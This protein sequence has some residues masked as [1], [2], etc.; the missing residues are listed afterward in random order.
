MSRAAVL[1][2]VLAATGCAWFG[3]GDPLGRRGPDVADLVRDLPD[4]A[5]PPARTD[6]PTRAEVMAAYERIYGRIPDP[7]EDHAVGRRL[8]DL[9]MSVGED[10]DIAGESA[11]YEAAISMYESLLDQ[12]EGDNQDQILYQL[13]RAHDLAGR[14]DRSLY[15]LD[16]L[17]AD[18]PDSRYRV[19]ARFRRGEIAFSQERYGDAES[20]YGYVVAQGPD[21]PYWQNA[22]YMRG[23]SQFKRSD[24]EAGLQSFFAVIDT[25]V[26]DGDDGSLAATDRELLDDSFRVVT[27]AL[28]YLDGADTL[29]AQMDAQGRPAWQYLAYQALA[30][31]YHERERYLDSVATWQ[32]FIDHNPLDP[33]APSAHLGMIETLL[34]ADFPSE[35]PPKKEAFVR[36]YGINS[37]FW[38]LHGSDVA[39]SYLEPLR[40]FLEELARTSHAG[41]Q[42]NGERATYLQA[43]EWYE[44]LVQTFPEDP[45]TAEYLFLLGEVYTEAGEHGPAV[46]AYQ[47]VVR[48]FPDYP[49][50]HEAGYAAILGLERMVADAA[51]EERELWQRV[52]IDAQIEFAFVFTGDPRAA[53]VQTDAAD[54]LYG[55]AEYDQAVELADNLLATWPELEWRLRETALRIQGHGR[56]E[57][58]RYAEAERAY[59]SLLAGPLDDAARPDITERL[60][61]TVYKQGEAAESEARTEDAVAHYLRLSDIAPGAQL[62]IQGHYD[63]VAVTEAAGQTVRAAGLLA[64]FRAAYPDH[65]LAQDV[66][67]RLA[68]MYEQTGDMTAAAGEYVRLAGEDPDP[69]VR[70]Q[71]LYRAAELY[72]AQ[73]DLVAAIDYFRDYANGYDEPIE[74]RLEAVHQLD[75]LYQRTGDETR[76]RHWL[77]E[78]IDIHRAMGRSASERATYLAAEAQYV[79]AEDARGAFAAVRLT[80]PLKDS[81]KRKQKALKDA[82]RAYEQAAEYQVAEFATAST[83][84]I[85]TL[86][87][88][89]AAAIMDSD[90]PDGLSELELA[91]YEILLEEQA[92]PFEEQAIS[93]HEINMRR[94]WDGLWNDWVEKSFTELGRLMPARFDKQELDVAYVESIH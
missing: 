89:L 36:R 7:R 73:D 47:R 54:S 15:Y 62:A 14:P 63:A 90:R 52:K 29:A 19:E 18:H 53:E 71:S 93:L 1:A 57:L 66:S 12:A 31:D 69:E 6:K 4:L 86:F 34:A 24:L 28:G 67:K 30:D 41:A 26:A 9:S 92:F 76:R 46:A 75:T 70:R 22:N 13:A 39:E 10:R 23:W 78:K 94:S 48:E 32:A 45:D 68:A 11:P 60:L 37:E 3:G 40:E 2:L 20:D 91:Q 72:L 87:T 43:A 85:G 44:E 88:D 84:R 50:A 17:I 27:L 61:A 77:A 58:G 49:D 25:L 38:A 51:P 55:L 79:F 21:T 82:V 80:H 8:A 59:R 74:Q 42:E 16:R 5:L 65:E 64:E 33:R 35:V 83:Y 81:L 56:F